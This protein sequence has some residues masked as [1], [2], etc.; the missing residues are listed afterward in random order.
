SAPKEKRMGHAGAIVE[1]GE[2]DASSKIERLR[3][4]G[5][6]VATRPSQIPELIHE[7]R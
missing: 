3:A 1:G 5:I 4:L 2:G 7:V 6:P